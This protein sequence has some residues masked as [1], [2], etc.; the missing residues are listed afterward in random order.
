MLAP[1][2]RAAARGGTGGALIQGAVV[3]E[4]AGVG[5]VTERGRLRL[6]VGNHSLSAGLG[7]HAQRHA[8]ACGLLQKDATQIFGACD[9]AGHD[10]FFSDSLDHTGG[11]C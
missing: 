4:L 2:Q 11:H 5:L 3:A 1:E 6:C 10:V 7:D 9:F 8:A